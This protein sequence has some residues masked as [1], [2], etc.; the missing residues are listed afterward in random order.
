VRWPI[1]LES[2]RLMLRDKH[3]IEHITLQP[4]WQDEAIA[5]KPAG[6]DAHQT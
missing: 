5:Y 3:K 2:A 1:L 4:E 6:I